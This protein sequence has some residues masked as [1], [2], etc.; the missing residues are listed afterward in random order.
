MWIC[1]LGVSKLHLKCPV[2]VRSRRVL[3]LAERRGEWA[4]EP[5]L[6][7]LNQEGHPLDCRMCPLQQPWMREGMMMICHS[8]WRLRGEHG[9]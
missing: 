9:A 6:L 8:D 3:L 7:V 1:P 4:E 2:V 5:D